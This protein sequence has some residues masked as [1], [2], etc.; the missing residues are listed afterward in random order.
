M[1]NENPIF[2]IHD[3]C[4][5]VVQFH[6]NLM[7]F[8]KTLK[9]TVPEY[10]EHIAET[11]KYY[12]SIS[13]S[14]YI[15][16]FNELLTPHVQYVSENDYGI[17]NDDYMKGPRILVPKMDFRLLWKIIEQSDDFVSDPEFQEN[18][19]I[20]I[21]KHLQALYICSTVAL[22]QIGI[23]DC[24][25]DKQ[26]QYLMD[27]LDNLRVDTEVK[28]RIDEMKKEEN[29]DTFGVINDILGENN[30]IGNIVKDI[31][32]EIDFGNEELNDPGA[33]IKLLCGNEGNKLQELIHMIGDKLQNK[34][35]TGEINKDKLLENAQDIRSKM[36]GVIDNIPGFDKL[37]N[38]T[39]LIDNIPSFDKLINDTTLI[40][41]NDP[42]LIEELND[43]YESLTKNKKEQ[44]K[45]IPKLL[46]KPMT[47]WTGEEHHQ[48]KE[49]GL[50]ISN[51]LGNDDDDE[52]EYEEDEEDEEDDKEDEDEDEYVENS[53]EDGKDSNKDVENSSNGK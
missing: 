1:S 13:R 39:T 7:K 35:R 15:R 41:T 40:D 17:F 6:N 36:S 49:Y 10:K 25:M 45:D 33:V 19:R 12:K 29:G 21:F 46:I 18:T 27:M 24:N 44:F 5:Q 32:D 37:I 11:V 43:T 50:Y 48:L 28:E 14:Q 53:S 4:K 23:F 51:T 42:K 16:E 34:I 26:K 22:R 38:D 2:T 3:K 52:E 31:A 9:S 30:F 47:E 20:S 8:L